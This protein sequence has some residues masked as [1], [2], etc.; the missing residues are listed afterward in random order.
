VKYVKCQCVAPYVAPCRF[1]RGVG[2]G[3]EYGHRCKFEVGAQHFVPHQEARTG[4]F[5]IVIV[6]VAVGGGGENHG[7]V[8]VLLHVEMLAAPAAGV[9]G[10]IV[11]ER[12]LV[13]HDKLLRQH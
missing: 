12:D 2:A 8:A 4:D 11:R 6:I 7:F 3:R 9:V 1:Q 10:L 5:S 13:D